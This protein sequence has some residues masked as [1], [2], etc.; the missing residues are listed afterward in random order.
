VAD[1]EYN[2]RKECKRDPR[3]FDFDV[4][5]Q[6]PRQANPENALNDTGSNRGI[7]PYNFSHQT[8]WEHPGKGKESRGMVQQLPGQIP[9]YI[10]GET[11]GDENTKCSCD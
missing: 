5:I 9:P 4:S 10:E 8:I 2:R 11:C 6:E 1:G 3:W 7:D